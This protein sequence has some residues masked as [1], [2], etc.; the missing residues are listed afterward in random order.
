[1]TVESPRHA[2]R[3]DPSA[4]GLDARL[5]HASGWP[6][7][8][9]TGSPQTVDL[10]L[11]NRTPFPVMLDT[12]EVA[13][14]LRPGVL[15]DTARLVLA[16]Q[17]EAAWGLSIDADTGPSG[18]GNLR[19]TFRSAHAGAIAP[20][21][22][23]TLRLDGV[24]VGAAGGSR[25]TRVEVSYTG[26]HHADGREV[27]GVHLLHVPLL[28]RGPP[29][30]LSLSRARSGASA[31][32]GP[33]LAGFVSASTLER[34][35]TEQGVSTGILNDGLTANCLVLRVMNVSGRPVRLSGDGD[36]ATRLHLNW[37]TAA[38]HAPWGL[39]QED[40][41]HL[42]LQLGQAPDHDWQVDGHSL[43]RLLPGTL[44]P[45]GYIELDLTIHSHA[46]TGATPFVLSFENLPDYDDDD[47]V[48]L[49]ELG[50]M[51]ES[52]AALSLVKPLD[53]YG[54]AARI[55]F[56]PSGMGQSG[57]GAAA[58]LSVNR[59]DTPGQLEID[60][61]NGLTLRRA[62]CSAEAR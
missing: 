52:D 51:V 42:T 39:M 3:I 55:A 36:A 56:H 12:A 35:H 26:F 46:E 45:G 32:A 5:L 40:G 23:I 54:R 28:R 48:L 15:E 19:L 30:P 18:Q 20:G 21:S 38:Q 37:S 16:P 25:A 7:L 59:S 1:M 27:A 9:I 62:G 11:T 31:L 8:S 29:E 10:E 34:P 50:P 41:D 43:R 33:F 22:A 14:L 49:P 17:S 47:L 6:A 4:A 13:V 58:T 60:A 2:T 61:P 57:A 44:P 53:L 24:S